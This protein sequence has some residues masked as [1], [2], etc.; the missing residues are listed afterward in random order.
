[1]PFDIV[2][3]S[4]YPFW[5]GTLT[6]LRTNVNDL[7]TRYGTRLRHRPRLDPRCRPG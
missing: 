7:A 6:Q 4:Y 1:V 5:H 2:A 3:L